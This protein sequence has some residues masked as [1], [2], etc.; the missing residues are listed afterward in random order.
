MWPGPCVKD[1]PHA[2]LTLLAGRPR[3]GPRGRHCWRCQRELLCHS[4]VSSEPPASIRKTDS[5]SSQ[6][7]T[8]SEKD[9]Q[10]GWLRTLASSSSKGLGCAHPRQRLS[11][12]RPWSPAVPA[13]D[14]ELS[15][16]LPALIR[17]SFYSYKSFE[18]GVAPNVALAPP[19]QQKVVSSPSCTTVVSRAPEPL[20]TCAQPRKRKLAVDTPSAP[21]TPAP[22]AALED[23][24]D[25]EAEVEVES[26]EEFT[27]SLS[28]LSSPSFTSSSSAKDLSSPGMHALPAAPTAPEAA[29]PAD[30]PSG[31]L[32]V[33]L[34]HLR[35]ALE[36]G[37]D[38][39]EAKEKFLHEVV[40]MRVK[41]EEKLSAALQAKR[42]LHQELEFLRVA[43]KEKLREATEAKRSLRKE[44][45]RLR[46]DN[47]K[48]MKE[49]AESR[50]RL[51]RELEQA[52]QVRVCDKGC[53]AG[54]LRAKY[55]AQ[56][57]DLQV[58]LQHAEAD[59]EQLRADLLRER[60]A[61]EHLEKVVKELQEQLWPRPRP[62]A[63]GIEGPGE[64]EP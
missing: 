17:D 21:E 59:R 40:K 42:S 23:D 9:K 61:R 60:E 41:Q 5:A 6:L 47:E 62:E 53:E 43:K 39:K 4:Q 64:L 12:F 27:S 14:K 11:A 51:K 22:M 45:E 56:I 8:S 16:H 44:I 49:A 28:S 20:A 32:E 15:P 63:T 34:E 37:L 31:G 48:K 58:K 52:R 35:Q 18:T 46:A 10:S 13:S 3:P 19:A 50:L 29:G 55:S 24:K 30:A 7:P 2:R 38:T 36:G 25:S 26:R 57:E 33:E 1:T 54:R